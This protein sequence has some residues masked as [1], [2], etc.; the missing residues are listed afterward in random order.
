MQ[1]Y[2]IDFSANE[3]PT[4]AGTKEL[5]TYTQSTKNGRLMLECTGKTNIYDMIQADLEDS[6]IENIMKRVMMGD[7]SVL[8]QSEPQ[9]IDAS[10]VPATMM[11]VQNHIVRMKEEFEKYPEEVKKE[12]GYSAEEYINEMGTKEF[13][14]K[15]SPYIEK[16]EKISMEKN[17]KEYEKKVKEGAK[18][19]Y[20][21][22]REQ[23]A[24]EAVNS[25][26][27]NE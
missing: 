18:L 25:K 6:K 13:L 12:F 4:P 9:Y 2:K 3:I 5:K 26:G 14:K 15:M 11:E 27:G 16:I 10:T 24:L 7:L 1:L 20:D 19:N 23:A 8:R 21:I 22:A 17:A